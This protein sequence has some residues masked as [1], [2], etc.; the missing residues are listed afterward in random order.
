VSGEDGTW[1]MIWHEIGTVGVGN[2]EQ[3]MLEFVGNLGACHRQA[4]LGVPCT[5]KEEEQ[6]N[7]VIFVT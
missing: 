4:T 3:L 5:K 6:I 2:P 7:I 1:G